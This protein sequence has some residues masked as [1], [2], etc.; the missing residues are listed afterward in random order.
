MKLDVSR[1]APD[2]RRVTMLG[3]VG[4]EQVLTDLAANEHKAP[5]F[6]SM[7]FRPGD[8]G[9]PHLQAFRGRIAERATG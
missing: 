8:A 7:K 6:V 2:P 5:T 1:Y 3:M 9:M 4:I